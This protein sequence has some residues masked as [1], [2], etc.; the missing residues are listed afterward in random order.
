MIGLADRLEI[1]EDKIDTIDK[2]LAKSLTNYAED[3]KFFYESLKDLG[4]NLLDLRMEITL[5]KKKLGMKDEIGK[6][7]IH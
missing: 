4:L 2:V 1:L 6:V 7:V 5:I 3:Q